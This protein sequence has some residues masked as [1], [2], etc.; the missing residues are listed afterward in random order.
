[1]AEAARASKGLSPVDDGLPKPKMAV[2]SRPKGAG[3]GPP[4]PYVKLGQIWL[5]SNVFQV[6]LSFLFALFLFFTGSG[7][8]AL[9][10]STGVDETD[11]F[12]KAFAWGVPALVLLA[13]Q[14]QFLFGTKN[15]WL[16]VGLALEYLLLR[17]LLA[18]LFGYGYGS[19]PKLGFSGLG[20][21]S[22][23]AATLTWITS[24]IVLV[25]PQFK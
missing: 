9:G 21:A 14:Q 24:L 1:M 15:E 6:L 19:F 16:A 17:S 3:A 13:T 23:L 7:L 20:H 12:M 2:A 5:H 8:R 18:M 4:N 10:L 25:L 11:Q 22:S